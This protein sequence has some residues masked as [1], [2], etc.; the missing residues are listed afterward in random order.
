M[1]ISEIFTSIQGEGVF[2]GQPSV[3][4][5]FYGCNLNCLWCDTPQG[6]EPSVKYKEMD[7]SEILKKIKKTGIKNVVLTGGEPLLQDKEEISLLVRKLLS[8]KYHVTIETNGSLSPFFAG[9]KGQIFWSISPKLDTKI[10][11]EV[12]KKFF[13]K[14]MNSSL[15]FVI[16]NREWLNRSKDLIKKISVQ[17]IKKRKIPIIFQ[18][19]WKICV[20][21]DLVNWILNDRFLQKFNIRVLPQVHKLGA[22]R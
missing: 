2:I 10:N 11:L 17:G 22:I 13:N 14:N 9:Y 18:P 12:L 7:V 20:F 21:S 15:K 1:K 4:V 8:N 16:K 5:R 19:M 6:R 3:F